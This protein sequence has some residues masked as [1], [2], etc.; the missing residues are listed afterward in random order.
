MI[1]LK[2]LSGPH[3]GKTRTVPTHLE[4]GEL[5]GEL[6]KE[7]CRWQIDFTEAIPEERLLWGRADMVF[8]ILAALLH[9]RGVWFEGVEYRAH[10][11]SQ[12]PEVA[13]A[14][15]D[16]VAYSGMMVCVES[17]DETGVKIGTRGTEHRMQ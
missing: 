9:G 14:V 15:E 13:G 11:L 10:Q 5:L 16:A 8:R 12:V 7:D 2:I 17:D 1:G 4:P 6:A 3:S